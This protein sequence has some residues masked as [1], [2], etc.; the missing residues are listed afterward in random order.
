MIIDLPIDDLRLLLQNYDL[1]KTR[2][3]QANAWLCQ[4]LEK[5]SPSHKSEE[6]WEDEATQ[7]EDESDTEP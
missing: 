5:V 4:N 1:F 3:S 7:I 2:V 6:D